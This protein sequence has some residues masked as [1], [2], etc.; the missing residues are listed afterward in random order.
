MLHIFSCSWICY[1]EIPRC[2]ARSK[3]STY[4]F[5]KAECGFRGFHGSKGTDD[6]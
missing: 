6:R 2:E 3:V 1:L 5:L 4:V